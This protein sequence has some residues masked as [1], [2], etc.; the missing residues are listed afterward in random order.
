M[1][2]PSFDITVV[3]TV[4][5]DPFAI[6]VA[7]YL[8]MDT[9]IADQLS[10]KTFAN[11]EFCPR[12]I[13]DEGDLDRIGHALDGQTIAIVSTCCG[14]HSRNGLA[15]RTLLTA[16]AA[17]DNGAEHVIL[18]EPDLFY[19]AQ[20]RGPRTDHGE[21]A[22]ARDTKDRKKF[23]GQPF[24][25]LL[26][27]QLLRQSGIDSVVTV[28]NHSV[29]VQRLF[30][31]EFGGRFYNMTPDELYCD[32]LTRHEFSHQAPTS[33]GFL[34]CAPDAGA[35]PFAR[36]V[37]E[38]LQ[39]RLDHYLL[40]P[41]LNLL[42][43]GKVRAGERR[44]SVTPAADSPVGIDDIPGRDI[45]VFDDMVRT[46]STVM[47]CC[48]VLKEAGARRVVF[49]VTHFHSSDEVKENLNHPAIDEIVTTNTL[50][51]ILNRD[52]Q[53]RLRKKMLVLKVEKWIATFLRNHCAERGTGTDE[54]PYSI[55]ISSKNPRWRPHE[56]L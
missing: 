30:A 27:A 31:R 48:K 43:M 52:M 55:D 45:I 41:E 22:F 37:H 13:S 24:S 33:C 23:D 15:M 12:F 56:H 18:V 54:P 5:D 16:R 36:R 6:D 49:V 51:S 38:R 1:R 50:P 11:S 28:H 10:L 29:S 8:G 42:L 2:E 21:T 9:E 53:G 46:G 26:Y 44:V 3:S 19:S 25:S 34:I 17:K 35:A 39:K 32:Y 40:K 7:H 4:S 14:N 20:D 47:E